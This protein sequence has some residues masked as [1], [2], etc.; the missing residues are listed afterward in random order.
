MSLKSVLVYNHGHV[1][2]EGFEDLGE[3]GSSHFVADHALVFMARG[4]L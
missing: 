3:W 2:I 1:K 4:L